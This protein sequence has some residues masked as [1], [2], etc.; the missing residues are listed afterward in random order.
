MK[1]DYESYIPCSS[2]L[3]GKTIKEVKSRFGLKIDHYHERGL[4][5]ASSRR[6]PNPDTVLDFGMTIKI[7]DADQQ[8]LA[9]FCKYFKLP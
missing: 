3:V 8:K 5:E 4:L 7:C 6:K 1:I 2:S 9:K